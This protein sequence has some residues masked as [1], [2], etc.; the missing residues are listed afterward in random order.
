M[1]NLIKKIKR[2]IDWAIINLVS[3]GIVLIFLGIL[4]VWTDFVLR[5]VIGLFVMVIAYIFFYLAYKVWWIK[6][7]VE[8]YFKL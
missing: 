4:I 5:L 7:E 3:T 6:R 8:K 2:K 1:Q